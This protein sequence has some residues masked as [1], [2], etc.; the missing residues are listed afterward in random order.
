MILP[1][2]ATG[3]AYLSPLSGRRALAGAR[4]AASLSGA[5]SPLLRRRHSPRSL[6]MLLS[7]A[8]R[9]ITWSPSTT[10]KCKPPLA[11]KPTIF[12]RHSSLVYWGTLYINVWTDQHSLRHGRCALQR[13][14]RTEFGGAADRYAARARKCVRRI[15]RPA[16][17][18]CRL[19]ALT[20]AR[21]K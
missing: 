19:Q 7:T 17:A 16:S 1:G 13:L 11:S 20:T 18:A 9:S 21:R 2:A 15:S 8:W 5:R 6:G 12:M 14:E 4:L 3:R 10:P